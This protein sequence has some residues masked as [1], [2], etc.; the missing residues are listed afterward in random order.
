MHRRRRRRRGGGGRGGEDD[1]GA[2]SAPRAVVVGGS[3]LSLRFVGK[4]CTLPRNR[5]SSRA[6]VFVRLS[7]IVSWSSGNY[8]RS[9]RDE[10]CATMR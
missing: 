4:S 5:D 10:N 7:S 9:V 2:V 3:L 8:V 6:R 1:R